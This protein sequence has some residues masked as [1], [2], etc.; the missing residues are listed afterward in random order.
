MTAC[1][2]C[3]SCRATAGR[4]QHTAHVHARSVRTVC[5]LLSCGYTGSKAS[6][7]VPGNVCGSEVLLS[8]CVGRLG[9]S[10]GAVTGCLL[11]CCGGLSVWRV[12][13][14]LSPQLRSGSVAS[15]L[16]CMASRTCVHHTDSR[17]KIDTW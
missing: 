5:L 14:A 8:V 10:C 6:V 15:G 11:A 16:A 3:E 2:L 13:V 9:P 12:T 1:I 4:I 7:R 17:C